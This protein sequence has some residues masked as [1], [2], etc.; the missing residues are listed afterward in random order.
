MRQEDQSN[1]NPRLGTRGEAPGAGA[2]ASEARAAKACLEHPAVAGPSMEAIVERENL[3]KALARVKRNKGAAGIDVMTVDALPAYLKQHWLTIRAQLLDG[4]Y[5]PQP[6]RRVEIPK[7][8]GGLR[9]LGIPTVLDRLIQ[10]AVLQ[11]LQA[12]WDR[13]FSEMSFGFRPGRSAHQALAKAQACIASGHRVVVDMDLDKFFERVHHDILMGLIAKRVTDK[14]LLKLIRGFLTAGV[15]EGGLVSP[16]EEGTPQGGPLSPLLS[17]LMLD[18]LDKELEKR[19]HRFVRYADD[20]NIYVRSRKAGE[21][22]LAGVEKFLER[23]LKLKVN[24]A[25]SAVAQPSVR[26]FLSFSFTRE[27]KPR[28]RIAP[29]AIARFKARVRELTRRTSGR[30]LEQIIEKL[31]LYLKGW[32]GYFGFC[33]TLSVL[34][35]LDEWIRRRL[36]AIV[37]TQ[38]KR[39]PVRFDEL[40]RCGVG[41]ELALKTAGNPRGPWRLANSAALTMALPKTLFASLGLIFLASRRTA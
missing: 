33:Q 18:V 7:A 11:V 15:L 31:S 4:T 23:R 26:K 5:K 8:S 20:C 29:Q 10:Q 16:T 41:R 6:V 1:L 38:W 39:G 27:R 25:K 32:R 17:N 9:P 2:G 21:R 24:K 37:W 22:V 14:R 36:R 3:K 30:S 13:T 34:R 19:G 12:D 40:R 28:R 35:K